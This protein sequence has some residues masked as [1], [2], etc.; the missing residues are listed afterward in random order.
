MK[1]LLLSGSLSWEEEEKIIQNTTRSQ[2]KSVF[3]PRAEIQQWFISNTTLFM[4]WNMLL[5]ICGKDWLMD[6]NCLPNLVHSEGASGCWKGATWKNSYKKCTNP[7]Q[8]LQTE[9]PTQR[10]DQ[11]LGLKSFTFFIWLIVGGLLIDQNITGQ[12]FLLV[13]SCTLFF[14]SKVF[15]KP[16]FKLIIPGQFNLISKFSQRLFQSRKTDVDISFFG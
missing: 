2:H 4:K 13:L 14:N 10:A 11:T 16:R 5:A 9:N 1:L 8:E 3:N 7:I 6:S 12:I 15:S